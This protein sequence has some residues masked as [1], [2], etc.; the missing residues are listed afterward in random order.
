MYFY[1]PIDFQYFV[2]VA[3]KYWRVMNKGETLARI[4]LVFLFWI[5][6]C[7]FHDNRGSF[8]L[9]VR[10]IFQKTNIFY[11]LICTSTCAYQ[12]VKNVS[13]SESFAYILNEWSLYNHTSEANDNRLVSPPEIPRILPGT[14][15][16]VSLHFNKPS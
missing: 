13:F 15:M 8:I 7:I 16:I 6:E 3:T 9:Y 11:P 5:V 12:E 10:E 4:E 1:I 2:A 14:P